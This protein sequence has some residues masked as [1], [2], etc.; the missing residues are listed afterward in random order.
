VAIDPLRTHVPQTEDD[1]SW[2]IG[3]AGGKEI[4]KVEI[5]GQE[6]VP[7][8]AS[9]LQDLRVAELMETLLLEMNRLMSETLKEVDRAR[10]NAHARQELHAE[11]CSKGWM[12]SSVN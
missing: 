4:A 6:D 10:G 8:L 7:F 12:V 2:Q 3:T 5:V 11:A 9:F 1:D